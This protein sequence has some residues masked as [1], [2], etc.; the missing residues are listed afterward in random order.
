MVARIATILASK[1]SR[2]LSFCQAFSE[3]MNHNR[4][5]M[6]LF[7]TCSFGSNQES[8]HGTPFC[9]CREVRG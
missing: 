1:H 8:G 7:L 2:S 5:I 3:K 9:F 6:P 4:R